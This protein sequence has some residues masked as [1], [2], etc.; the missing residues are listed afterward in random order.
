MN[1]ANHYSVLGNREDPVSCQA[2][3]TGLFATGKMYNHV[4]WYAAGKDS[5]NDFV[6]NYHDQYLSYARKTGNGGP[7]SLK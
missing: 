6:G 7:G 1:L 4:A 2:V 3:N 5:S